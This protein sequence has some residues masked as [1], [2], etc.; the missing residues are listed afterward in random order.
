MAVA[1]GPP[2][3]VIT[4]PGPVDRSTVVDGPVVAK[5]VT[6]IFVGSADAGTPTLWQTGGAERQSGYG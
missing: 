5:W 6:R 2:L 1:P 4:A 3:M